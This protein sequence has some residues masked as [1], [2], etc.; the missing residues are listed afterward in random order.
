MDHLNP[1]EKRGGYFGSKPKEPIKVPT[2][3]GA[4]EKQGPPLVRP[5]EPKQ[6]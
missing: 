2:S 3:K 5:S 1:K 6:S 4:S